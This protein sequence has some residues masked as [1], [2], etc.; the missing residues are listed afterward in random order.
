MK[1]KVW[2]L[3]PFAA[4]FEAFPLRV[5]VLDLAESTACGSARRIESRAGDLVARDSRF[6]PKLAPESPPRK[7]APACEEDESST[8]ALSKRRARLPEMKIKVRI[9]PSLP[10]VLKPFLCVLAC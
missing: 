7:E 1:C 9:L 4:D 5:G 3:P 6:A 2:I 8:V 10:L